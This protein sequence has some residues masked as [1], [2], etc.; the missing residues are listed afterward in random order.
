MTYK[1]NYYFSAVKLTSEQD[2]YIYDLSRC[3]MFIFSY[4]HE[5]AIFVDLGI[6]N[7]IDLIIDLALRE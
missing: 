5:S 6:S 3:T 2:N 1:S 4:Y 7:D